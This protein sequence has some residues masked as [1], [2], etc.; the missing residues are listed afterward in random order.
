MGGQGGGRGAR[1]GG[2][3]GA[4]CGGWVRLQHPHVLQNLRADDVTD[5]AERREIRLE[6]GSRLVLDAD[7][8]ITLSLGAD[9]RRVTVLCGAVWFD[10]AT[11]G[12]A[13]VVTAGEGEIEVTGIAF[14]VAMLRDGASV[15]LER[16]RCGSAAGVR[17]IWCRGSG[18]LD[19][20]WPWRG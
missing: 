12:Q 14:E 1:G 5:R 16:G 20:G 9:A 18:Q 19:A 13:F 7:S 8:A 10:V 2:R 4:G 11:T 3:S 15:A 17:G 6:D